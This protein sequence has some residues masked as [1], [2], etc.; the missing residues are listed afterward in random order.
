[1]VNLAVTKV[2]SRSV[3]AEVG[4]S[5][6]KAAIVS[7]FAAAVLLCA[8]ADAAT[9]TA[10]AQA[11]V[12]KPLTL[13]SLQGLDLGTITLGPGTWSNAKVSLTQTGTFSCGANLICTGAPMA[14]QFNVSGSKS[15][16][17]AISAP[18][19]TLTNQADA[20]K[21]LVMTL[22]APSTI[23]L[24]NSGAPGT[25]FSVGGSI[26]LNST[27]PDGTYSGTITIT[28]DYQ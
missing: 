27:T 19:V 24:T 5:V 6:F 17:V 2:A 14:A 10:S 8:P 12:V 25:N 20:T 1:L 21:T 18:N 15:N 9:I 28:A 23:T 22:S 16:V 26:T 4:K 3:R 13:T 11:N 7:A